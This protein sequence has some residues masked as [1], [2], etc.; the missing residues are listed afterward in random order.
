VN[1]ITGLPLADATVE[2]LVT[3]PESLALTTDPSDAD[4]MAETNWQTKRPG[5]K[6]PGTT[7]G[8]YTVQTKNVTAATY[9]WD[10]VTTNTTFTIQ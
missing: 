10:G 4:G 3:G 7:P 8:L 5:K 9:H 6:N 1:G 2:L